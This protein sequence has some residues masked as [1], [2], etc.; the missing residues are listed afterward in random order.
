MHW[1][2]KGAIQKVLGVVPRG[3][4][5]HYQLQRRAGGLRDVTREMTIK[6]D[7]WR[8]MVDMLARCDVRVP[9]ARMLE[10]GT[11][12]YTL[13]PFAL[14]AAGA[15]RVVTVDLNRYL[16]RELTRQCVEVLARPEHI[17]SLATT[18]GVSAGDVEHRL[19]RVGRALAGGA[20]VTAATDGVV[21]Y[22]AP[23]DASATTLA[24]GSIDIVFSNSVLEHVPAEVIAAIFAESKRLLPPR[25]VMIHGVNC[26]DH[27][28]YSDKSINQ[29]HYLTYSSAR[30]AKWQNRFLYQNRL[31]APDFTRLAREAGFAI[32]LDTSKARPERLA[33]LDELTVHPEFARYTRE[34]LAITSIDFVARRP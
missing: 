27:Y 30:F 5:L 24:D 4:D 11:G 17:E 22:H 7:D 34:E 3:D 26:G 29:L 20:D 13:F 18:A 31:R 9:G 6:V 28:A 23:A 12:W 1:R 25:G 19:A 33:Q 32:D 16:R 10:I 21:E 2:I 8:V 14:Y 15:A